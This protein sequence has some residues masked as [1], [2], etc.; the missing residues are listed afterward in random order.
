MTMSDDDVLDLVVVVFTKPQKK[1][2]RQKKKRERFWKVLP[3][4][5]K[6]FVTTT[7]HAQQ[8]PLVVCV[9]VCVYIYIY[10]YVRYCKHRHPRARIE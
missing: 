8:Y 5:P 1:G 2:E 7:F 9:C 6:T 3:S 4:S 10:T